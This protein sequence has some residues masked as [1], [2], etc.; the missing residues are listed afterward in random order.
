MDEMANSNVPQI[1]ASAFFPAAPFT[2][3]L[4]ER[5]GASLTGGVRA[6]VTPARWA[7]SSPISAEPKQ[8]WNITKYVPQ[9]DEE[10]VEKRRRSVYICQRGVVPGRCLTLQHLSKVKL[11][12]P[13][14]P[15]E[16]MTCP[17]GDI[18]QCFELDEEEDL[19]QTAEACAAKCDALGYECGGW[20]FQKAGTG[21]RE[22]PSCCLKRPGFDGASCRT[23]ACCT[24]FVKKRT[25]SESRVVKSA[26]VT[27]GMDHGLIHVLPRRFRG[28]D[29]WKDQL[30]RVVPLGPKVAHI[31]FYEGNMCLTNG[32]GAVPPVDGTPV[33]LDFCDE[34]NP[35]QRWAFNGF[36]EGRAQATETVLKPEVRV[37]SREGGEDNASVPEITSYPKPKPSR[38]PKNPDAEVLE[39]LEEADEGEE[40]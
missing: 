21:G 38:V 1:A 33:W 27:G 6:K 19:G 7:S 34:E 30:W 28:M 39:D 13:D 17:G 32:A 40:E 20:E 31:K 12:V 29:N 23:D 14:D 24:A 10:D 11:Q 16:A 18:S 22:E 36:E 9:E 4:K 25:H 3:T 15:A 2:L 5:K 37:A 8:Q 35:D 26:F